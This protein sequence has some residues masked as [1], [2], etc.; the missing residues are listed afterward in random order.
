[1]SS[2]ISTDTSLM[3]MNAP[4]PAPSEVNCIMRRGCYVMLHI[5]T[6]LPGQ[7]VEWKSCPPVVVEGSNS[8]VLNDD[9]WIEKLDE[10]LAIHIQQACD[11]PHYRINNDPKD[12][13]LYALLRRVADVE[14]SQYEGMDEL[15]AVVALS[16]LIHPTSTGD[17][18]CAWILRYGAPESQIKAV[19][20]RGIS[21]DV[22]LSRNQRDWLSV[23]D[24]ECLRQLM[25]WVSKRKLM[26]ERVHRAFWNHEYAMRSFYLDTR[27]PIVVSGLEALLNVGEQNSGLQFKSRVR[28]LADEFGLQLSDDEISKAWKLRSKLVH[29][30][31]FLHNLETILPKSEHSDLYEKMESLLR[32][33]VRRCLLDARFGD[34][35]R[36]DAAVK[37]RWPI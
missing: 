13:H 12:R 9:F 36:D 23:E 8:F 18:Y 31:G 4:L 32:M 27:W 29:A 16:R 33:A 25:P 34:C 17:R 19:Q 1:M 2:E 3:D 37:A 24:A 14:A 10:E 11:P 30:E 5:G 21:P 26:H 7:T 35:F 22:L 15:H 20:Y 28:L 6:G